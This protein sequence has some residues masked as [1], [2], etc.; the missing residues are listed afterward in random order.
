MMPLAENPYD[1]NSYPH[2]YLDWDSGAFAQRS[3]AH[4][5]DYRKIPSEEELREFIRGKWDYPIYLPEMLAE[6]LHKMLMEDKC[7]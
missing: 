6:A 1:G 4:E 2:A 7:E 3:L 5:L